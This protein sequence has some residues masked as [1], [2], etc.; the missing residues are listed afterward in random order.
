MDLHDVIKKATLLPSADN[1]K[2]YRLQELSQAEKDRK[3]NERIVKTPQN[4]MVYILIHIL[5]SK[6]TGCI[7]IL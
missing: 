7:E 4:L 1:A 5:I 3:M 6:Y 2:F